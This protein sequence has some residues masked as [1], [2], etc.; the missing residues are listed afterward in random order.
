MSWKCI[1]YLS[2]W[3][4]STHIFECIF[5]FK[6]IIVD[7]IHY[8]MIR[9]CGNKSGLVSEND[10]NYTK[11]REKKSSGNILFIFEKK[12]GFHETPLTMDIEF[13]GKIIFLNAH[14]SIF[15]FFIHI[16]LVHSRWIC[17]ECSCN[18]IRGILY[19]KNN[20]ILEMN[21]MRRL[22]KKANLIV[23]ILLLFSWK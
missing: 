9:L 11:V 17:V 20:C 19:L 22:L 16:I 6:L 21:F 15:F 8:F 18:I 10:W 3:I 4:F 1:R 23:I 12:N 14:F 2:E 5:Q 13:H 7:C